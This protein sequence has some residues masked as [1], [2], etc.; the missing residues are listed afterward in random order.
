MHGEITSAKLEDMRALTDHMLGICDQ[1]T[2]INVYVEQQACNKEGFP[3]SSLLAPLRGVM[4]ELAGYFSDAKSTF[5]FSW[6][7]FRQ[8]VIDTAYAFD[9][10]DGELTG[11]FFHAEK[12]IPGG[13][14]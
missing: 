9:A 2:A 6:L 5:Y 1:I 7:Q 14:I 10:T 8:D 3:E 13:P 12:Q 11:L 4:D